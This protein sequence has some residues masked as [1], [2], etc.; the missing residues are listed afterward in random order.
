MPTAGQD[1][2]RTAPHPLPVS[3]RA[4]CQRHIGKLKILLQYLV[5]PASDEAARK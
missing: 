1:D 4:I 2:G 5:G 3:A